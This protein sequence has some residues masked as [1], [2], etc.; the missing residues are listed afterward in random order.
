MHPKYYVQVP[1]P[2]F[3]WTSAFLL[4]NVDVGLQESPIHVYI[5][6]LKNLHSLL[7]ATFISHKSYSS[8]YNSS[9]SGITICLLQ[10]QLKVNRPILLL[11]EECRP[12]QSATLVSVISTLRRRRLENTPRRNHTISHIS[13]IP[14]QKGRTAK[15]S[16]KRTGSPTCRST[17]VLKKA[18]SFNVIAWHLY[19]II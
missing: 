7:Q 16:Q 15:H 17:I 4:S 5:K 6:L 10:L 1:G 2:I 3:K 13:S 11:I 19:L 14:I 9:A 18:S 8:H 12:R